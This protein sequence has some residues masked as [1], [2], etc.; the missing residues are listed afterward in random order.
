MARNVI[1][2]VQDQFGRGPFK[3]GFSKTWVEKR[4]DHKNLTPY[5]KQFGPVHKHILFGEYSGCGCISLEQLRRWFTKREYKR[6]KK[7][8]YRAVKM[9]VDRVLAESEIQCFFG[10]TTQLTEGIKVI[11]LY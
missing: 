9:D 6:L 7:L 5:F 11:R 4:A 1:F 2:R 8:G 3:P 10:R